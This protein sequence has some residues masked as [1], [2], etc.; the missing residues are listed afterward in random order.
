MQ[1][2][3]LMAHCSSD[4]VQNNAVR[5]ICMH[6]EMRPCMHRRSCIRRTVV[7]R[8]GAGGRTV[9][10]G[11]G[12]LPVGIGGEVGSVKAHRSSA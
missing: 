12:S 10:G 3:Q 9:P 1:N 4:S 2:K 6:N 7:I 11:P 8:A 5:C